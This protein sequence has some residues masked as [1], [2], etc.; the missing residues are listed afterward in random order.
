M[1]NKKHI[2]SNFDDFL[3]MEG[4]LEESEAVAVKRV[5]AYALKEKMEAENISLSRLAKELQTSRTAIDRIF[6]VNNTSITLCTMEKVAKYVGRR[7][8]LSFA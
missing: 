1:L 4:L 6:D 3:A 8:V 2:G 5:L 7:L